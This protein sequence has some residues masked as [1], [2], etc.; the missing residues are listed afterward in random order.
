MITFT[1]GKPDDNYVSRVRLIDPIPYMIKVITETMNRMEDKGWWNLKIPDVSVDVNEDVLGELIKGTVSFKNGFVVSIGQ[2]DILQRT[3]GQNWQFHRDENTTTV[4]ITGT[5]R[6]TDVTLGFDVEAKLRNGVQ[7]FTSELILP[8]VAFDMRVIRD[9]YTDCIDVKIS[10]SVSRTIIN[11]MK[12]LP[13]NNITDIFGNLFDLD[14]VTP[15]V[16]L[17]TS[18]FLQPFAMD[19]VENVLAYPTICYDCPL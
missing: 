16:D 2:L 8:E 9:V 17:W 19:L 3:L 11:K 14:F 18:E 6:M 10:P 12:F 1:I 4:E 15:G 5:M 13:A 7:H